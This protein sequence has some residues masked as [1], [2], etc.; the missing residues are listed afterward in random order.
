MIAVI[1]CK[2]P[3]CKFSLWEVPFEEPYMVATDKC[4]N[5]GEAHVVTINIFRMKDYKEA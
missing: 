2:N 1:E 4:P 3:E 5:C